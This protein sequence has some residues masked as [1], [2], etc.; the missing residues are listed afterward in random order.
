MANLTFS[1]IFKDINSIFL[2][3]NKHAAQLSQRGLVV[4]AVYGTNDATY[5]VYTAKGHSMFV[6]V[7]TV[8]SQT[9]GYSKKSVLSA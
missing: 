1:P 7:D 2:Y 5:V 6:S 3:E 8:Q 4:D 9:S